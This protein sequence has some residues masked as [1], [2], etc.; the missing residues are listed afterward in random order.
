MD[1]DRAHIGNESLGAI[2]DGYFFLVV[3]F[4]TKLDGDVLRD[5][6]VNGASVC[7]GFDFNKLLI[8]IKRIA[9]GKR[10][11]A[12]PWAF[13]GNWKFVKVLKHNLLMSLRRVGE[14]S[15]RLG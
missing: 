7:H 15:R 9:K 11:T 3:L 6:H 14:S 13:G 8:R 5:T 12:E 2:G 10:P 4:Q 1:F